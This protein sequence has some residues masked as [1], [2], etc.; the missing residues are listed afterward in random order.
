[1]RRDR[2]LLQR[3]RPIRNRVSGPFLDLRVFCFYQEKVLKCWH[4]SRI[5]EVSRSRVVALE[6]GIKMTISPI[7]EACLSQYIYAARWEIAQFVAFDQNSNGGSLSP[8]ARLDPRGIS[9]RRA[10]TEPSAASTS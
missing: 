1:M 7:F 10:P 2:G 5:A 4:D 3:N 9:S 6:L 8:S